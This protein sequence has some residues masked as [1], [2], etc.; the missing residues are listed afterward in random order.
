MGIVASILG[1]YIDPSASSILI[2][3]AAACFILLAGIALAFPF[4]P[5]GRRS[6]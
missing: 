4:E 3:I 6:V 5:M 1:S 2:F